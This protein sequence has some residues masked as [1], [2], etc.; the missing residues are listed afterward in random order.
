MIKMNRILKK[1]D[2]NPIITPADM[3]EEVLYTFNPGAIKH[4][5]EYIMIMDATTLDDIHR[6][7][8]ARSKDGYNFE[9]DE[10]PIDWPAPDPIHP[11]TCTYD[12]RIT[13]I[14][15]E[16]IQTGFGEYSYE[17]VRVDSLSKKTI[18]MKKVLQKGPLFQIQKYLICFL[19]F[20]EKK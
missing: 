4:N 13:K 8:L 9:I 18:E 17:F 11:E 2:S 19:H 14:G 1:Y 20:L 10:K 3:P 16:Y 5:D 6:L 12:P 7:W 15:D